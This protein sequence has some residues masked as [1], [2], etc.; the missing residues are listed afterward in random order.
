MLSADDIKRLRRLMELREAKDEAEKAAKEAA[1]DFREAEADLF[2][3]LTDPD[4]GDVRRIPPVD[5]GE[6]FGR[7]AFQARETFYGRVIP[8]MEQDAL[9]YFREQHTLDEHTEIKFSKKRLNELVRERIEDNGQMP[10]GVDFY[11]S[12][13][14]TITRQK[15]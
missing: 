3:I 2:E 10:P 1:K 7:V 5:L 9:D 13:G 12:R 14:V 4:T 6:P 11:P 8:G 15:G